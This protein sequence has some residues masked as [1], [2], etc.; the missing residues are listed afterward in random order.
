MKIE[1]FLGKD[2]CDNI[3]DL[4][5]IMR[6]QTNNGVNEFWISIDDEYPALCVLTNGI[7][8]YVHYFKEEGEP[9]MRVIPADD[10]G[11]DKEGVSIFYTNTDSEEITVE[12]SSVIDIEK[13]IEIVIEFFNTHKLPMCILWEEL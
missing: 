6:K 7:Y 11:L 12:N 1:H 5:D 8:A 3:D 9:G 4:Y 10:N 13:A 2:E